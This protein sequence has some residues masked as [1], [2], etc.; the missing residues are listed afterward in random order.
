MVRIEVINKMVQI[1]YEIFSFD[2]KQGHVLKV[3]NIKRH[4]LKVVNKRLAFKVVKLKMVLD[5]QVLHLGFIHIR[6]IFLVLERKVL[7]YLGLLLLSVIHKERNQQ[8]NRQFQQ[9]YNQPSF[10]IFF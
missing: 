6:L 4:M 9:E 8:I 1:H 7:D 5:Q 2:H 3:V 10:H